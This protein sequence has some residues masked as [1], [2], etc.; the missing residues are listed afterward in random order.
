MDFIPIVDISNLLNQNS[1]KEDWKHTAE[2]IFRALNGI[3][4]VYVKN[5]GIDS[6]T[7]SVH[8]N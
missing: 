8:K 4:F 1:S 5:H 3:G 2:E 6:N 7:V